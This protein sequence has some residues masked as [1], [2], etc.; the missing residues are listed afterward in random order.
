MALATKRW[1]DRRLG[2]TRPDLTHPRRLLWSGT[3]MDYSDFA[4]GFSVSGVTVTVKAG[5]IRHGTRTAISVAQADI[6][7]VADHTWIYV[8]YTFG[9]GASL[10]SSTTEPVMTE[11]AANWPLHK[12][13]LANGVAS[14]EQILHLGDI[15]IPG[16]FA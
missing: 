16:S 14:I 3:D 10:T 2:D 6:S 1:V 13:R 12:W 4:F 15:I 5:K 8:V 11:T 7:I 9:G